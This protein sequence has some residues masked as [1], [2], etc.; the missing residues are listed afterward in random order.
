[1]QQ[2]LSKQAQILFTLLWLS[3]EALGYAGALLIGY[4]VLADYTGSTWPLIEQY[5]DPASSFL[6]IFGTGLT[7]A[8]VYFP[9]TSKGNPWGHSKYFVGPIVISAALIALAIFIKRG[10]V[11]HV[12]VN[13]FA[14][15][16]ISGGLK[17]SIPRSIPGI[18]T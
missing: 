8:S 6:T 10:D 1:M 2:D 16:A 4:S 18:P 12:A 3:T 17:R 13:G 9:V 7:A 14:L 11:P 15:L 5:A